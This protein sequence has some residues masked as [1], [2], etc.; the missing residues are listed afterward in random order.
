MDSTFSDGI[1]LIKELS[2]KAT[3]KLNLYEKDIQR[4]YEENNKHYKNHKEKCEVLLATNS[5][6]HENCEEKIAILKEKIG[7]SNKIISVN[8]ATLKIKEEAISL[9]IDIDNTTGI[10]LL[11]DELNQ[12]I[13]VKNELTEFLNLFERSLGLEITCVEDSTVFKFKHINEFNKNEHYVSISCGDEGFSLKQCA[14]FLSE[15]HNL[16]QELNFSNDL[17]KFIRHTRRQFQLLYS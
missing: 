11:E 5:Y 14:P 13:K 9:K 3:Q 12:K 10:L 15:I 4:Y 1:K 2:Q 6:N 17:S 16:V 8:E 7:L